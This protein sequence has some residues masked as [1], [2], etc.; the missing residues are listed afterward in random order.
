MATGMLVKFKKGF[1]SPPH[2]H[3]ITY[4]AIVIEGKL[5]NDDPSAE[6]MWMPAGSYWQQPAGEGQQNMAYLE[7]NHGPYLVKPTDKAFDNGERPI[8]IDV[9]NMA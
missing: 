6:A 4:R 7:I 1:S 5:H 9:T 8:N 3:N 2:I